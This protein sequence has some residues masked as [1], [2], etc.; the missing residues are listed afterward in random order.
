MLH[1]S[2]A[3]ASAL[4]LNGPSPKPTT[5]DPGQQEWS[6]ALYSDGKAALRMGVWECSPGRF[7]VTRT[8]A[9]ICHVLSGRATLTAADGSQIELSAGSNFVLPVGWQGEWDVHEQIRKIYIIHD[10]AA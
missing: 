7:T 8:T 4:T 9:E 3:E 1:I 10:P 2:N 5:L 6:N